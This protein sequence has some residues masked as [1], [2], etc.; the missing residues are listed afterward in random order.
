MADEAKLHSPIRSTFEA[1]VMQCAV[2]CCHG[3]EL[4]L[5][6]LT[7][8]CR[9]FRVECISFAERTSQINGFIEI[10]KAAVDQ[11]SSRPPKN[12]RDPF[13]VHVWLSKVLWHFLVQPPSWSSPV[14]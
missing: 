3:E 2:R 8:D 14:T 12:D 9:C 13:L 6:L 7:S 10:Q 4:G 1:L 5:F 11:T